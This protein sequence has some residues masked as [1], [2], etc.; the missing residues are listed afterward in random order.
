MFPVSEAIF[1]KK[2]VFLTN[3]GHKTA[4]AIEES[5]ESD[6]SDESNYGVFL[7]FLLS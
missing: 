6:E 7:L 2:Y 4:A 3:S 1:C 5:D